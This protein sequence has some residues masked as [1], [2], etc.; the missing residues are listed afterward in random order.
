MGFKM[1]KLLFFFVTIFLANQNFAD[2]IKVLQV[3]SG[4]E[5]TVGENQKIKLSQAT[6]LKDQ[7]RFKTVANQ[8]IKIQLG[9]FYELS[10]L[11]QSDVFVDL[12]D[13]EGHS[14]SYTIQLNLG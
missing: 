7:G 5:V 8:F 6:I 13:I 10:L 2:Q 4:P 14:N 1:R 3:V 12:K 11:D 9:E